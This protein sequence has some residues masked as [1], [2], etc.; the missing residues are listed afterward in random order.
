MKYKNIIYYIIYLFIT[1]LSCNLSED[2]TSIFQKYLY[3][4]FKLN[5]PVERKIFII[6]DLDGCK[7]CVSYTLNIIDT[8]IITNSNFQIILCTDSK[9]LSAIRLEKYKNSKN[10][11]LDIGRKFFH[12]NLSPFSNCIINSNNNGVPPI[13]WT[14]N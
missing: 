14:N 12:L 1:F 8:M 6:V 13:L 2:Q 3:D 5:I 11:L 9:Y 7:G 10:V 4:N